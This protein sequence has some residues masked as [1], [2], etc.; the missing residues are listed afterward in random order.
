M[1][2]LITGAGGFIGQ[3]LARAV[4]DHRPDLSQLVLTDQHITKGPQGAA[5]QPGD[6]TDPGFVDALLAPGF[7]LVFHLASLP[8][9]KAESE[10]DLGHRINLLAPIALAR[11]VAQR[12]PG[13]RFVFASSIAVYG[14]LRETVT[15]ATPCDPALSYGAHKRMTEVLL[16]DL[17]RRGDLNAVSLR[18][19]GVVARPATETGHG[20]A[21]MSLLFHKIAAG[22]GYDCPVPETARCWWLSRP[23]C[24]EA[25]L[26]AS[27]LDGDAVI[28]PPVLHL[29][30]GAV[31]QAVAEVTGQTSRVTWGDDAR[32]TGL[33]GALP[34]LD[35][36]PALKAGFR[37]DADV[38][39]LVRNA[40]A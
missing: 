33:F 27:T 30:T 34:E 29:T 25:F 14:A 8:G 39:A 2:V 17:T 38:R 26:H 13:A 16:A 6:L 4:A 23:A 40:L 18:L 7:D 37:A 31:A 5:L 10:P 32:L 9:A 36:S 11:G 12:K 21:F 24:V 20:S 15:P 35:A 28:Q 1:R 3:A 22:Q 19:P